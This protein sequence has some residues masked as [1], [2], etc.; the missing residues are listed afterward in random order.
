MKLFCLKSDN[1]DQEIFQLESDIGKIS[2]NTI[3]VYFLGH[4]EKNELSIKCVNWSN[5]VA[6]SLKTH[7]GSGY[8]HFMVMDS[9]EILYIDK[10]SKK[11]LLYEAFIKACLYYHTCYNQLDNKKHPINLDGGYDCKYCPDNVLKDYLG[12]PHH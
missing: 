10:N 8:T 1:P 11:S 12:N 5:D 7:T 6:E 9:S 2:P 4:R 3:G